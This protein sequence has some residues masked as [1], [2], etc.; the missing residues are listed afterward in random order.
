MSDR[1]K[2]R[3]EIIEEIAVM[4]EEY[5]EINFETCGDNILMDPLLHGGPWTEEN[6]RISEQ[7]SILS[8]IHSS[9]YHACKE[10]AE[11]IRAMD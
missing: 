2:I 3:R 10:I 9:K 6:V 11:Q 1:A 7:C 5:G 8:T 4:V